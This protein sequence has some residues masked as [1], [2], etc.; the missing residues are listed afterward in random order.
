MFIITE[1]ITERRVKIGAAEVLPKPEWIDLSRDQAEL[2]VAGQ[3]ADVLVPA[4]DE[5]IDGDDFVAFGQEPFTQMR[6]DKTAAAGDQRAH[7]RPSD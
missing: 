7:V 4:G 1:P 6:P 2:R 5:V 3:V